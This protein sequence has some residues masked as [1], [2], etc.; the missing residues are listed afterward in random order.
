M[1]RSSGI[2][3]SLWKLWVSLLNAIYELTMSSEN[4]IIV[5][6]E[7]G[8]GLIV[9][10]STLEGKYVER[11]AEAQAAKQEILKVRTFDS[12]AKTRQRFLINLRRIIH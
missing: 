2:C 10:A 1:A 7:P 5:F 11:Y 8:K 9:I 6:D 12:F 3:T 4:K